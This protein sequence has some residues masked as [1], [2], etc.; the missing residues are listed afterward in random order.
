M[1]ESKEEP[2]APKVY[3]THNDDN[4]FLNQ[5][6][7]Q[8]WGH[9][10][11][12]WNTSVDMAKLAVAGSRFNSEINRAPDPDEA[13]GIL[14]Q[15][16]HVRDFER[17]QIIEKLKQHSDPKVLFYINQLPPEEK[18]NLKVHLDYFSSQG[19]NYANFVLRMKKGVFPSKGLDAY[20][21]E[22][23]HFVTPLN[24]WLEG[25]AP[26]RKDAKAF[27]TEQDYQ[28]NFHHYEPEEVDL[29][30]MAM[31]PFE[32]IENDP[33]ISWYNGTYYPVKKVAELS[34][35]KHYGAKTRLTNLSIMDETLK[36]VAI[37]N[38]IGG[39]IP[40]VDLVERRRLFD[41]LVN[42]RKREY[43]LSLPAENIAW[44]EG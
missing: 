34:F 15:G 23:E 6:R 17:K 36:R 37:T 12:E 14:G 29:D 18:K 43:E 38:P 2:V 27:N 32:R 13:A 42:R 20:P 25:I 41:D 7:Q 30:S 21:G 16:N 44:L 4:L 3:L 11:L 19:V 26:F 8:G 39:I 9:D 10:L 28:P 40:Q 22:D 1:A 24:S 31:R 5:Y 33:T 35:R